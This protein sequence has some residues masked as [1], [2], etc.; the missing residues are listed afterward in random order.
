MLLAVSAR[1]L[2]DWNEFQIRLQNDEDWWIQVCACLAGQADARFV[3][4][5]GDWFAVSFGFDQF[6]QHL[7][8][9]IGSQ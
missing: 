9:G 5:W 3:F 2:G 4:S 1:P 8:K 6:F 7:G